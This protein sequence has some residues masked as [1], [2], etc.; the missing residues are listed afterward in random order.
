MKPTMTIPQNPKIISRLRLMM[1]LP[2]RFHNGHKPSFLPAG[3]PHDEVATLALAACAL[4]RVE[5]P[6]GVSF[7][8]LDGIA[9]PSTARAT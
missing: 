1:P 8:G 6:Y 9:I 5:W 4:L 2:A 7:V 3:V